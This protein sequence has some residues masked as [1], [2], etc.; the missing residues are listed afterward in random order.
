MK[1]TSASHEFYLNQ[2]INRMLDGVTAHGIHYISLV[3]TFINILSLYVLTNKDFKHN[4]YD[5]LRCRCF[6]NLLVCLIGIFDTKIIPENQAADYTGLYSDWYLIHIPKRG[7]LFGSAISDNL[8]VMN[9]LV[10]FYEIKDSIFFS[11]SKKVTFLNRIFSI[12]FN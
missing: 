5:F 7:I 10:S 4:F 8:L 3:G 6:C 9:R 2:L 11:L 12:K 1:N